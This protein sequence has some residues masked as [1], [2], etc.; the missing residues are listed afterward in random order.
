MEHYL[1]TGEGPVLNK[2]IEITALHKNGHEFPV[3]LSI[4]DLRINEDLFFMA[5]LS[6]ITTRK[7]T[8]AELIKKEAELLQSKIL[9][10]KKDEFLSIASHELKTPLTTIKAY[11]QIAL[12]I[13]KKEGYKTITG[14]LQK[15]DIHTSKLNFLITELLDLSKIQAGKFALSKTVIAFQPFLADIIQSM[16]HVITTHKITLEGN[17]TVNVDID[18][19]RIEQVITNLIDNAAKYSP[20]KEIVEVEVYTK[21]GEVVVSVK[22]YGIGIA[23]NN[24]QH[25]FSRFY[26]VDTAAKNVSGMGIGLF[27]SKEIIGLHGGTITVQSKENEGSTFSFSLPVVN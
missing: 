11:S 4:S 18:A 21:N 24:L 12:H 7:N 26:R 8:E 5:F 15:I 3:N 20:G 1:Q 13:G 17:T 19:F 22:D 10:E 6:D 9:D 27:I 25:I 2:T 16:Q 14:F 23:E